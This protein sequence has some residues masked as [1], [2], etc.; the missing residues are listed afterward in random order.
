MPKE[1]QSFY[2]IQ[3]A[4]NQCQAVIKTSQDKAPSIPYDAIKDSDR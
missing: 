4:F 1:K 3:S 2:H